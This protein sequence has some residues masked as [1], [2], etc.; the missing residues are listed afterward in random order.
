MSVTRRAFFRWT[1]AGLAASTLGPAAALDAE[2]AGLKT[3]GATKTT[4]I[5]PYCSVGCGTVIHSAGGQVVQVDGDPEHPINRG[6]LCPKGASVA[7]LRQNPKRLTTPLYRAPGATEWK[8][9][10]WDWTVGEIAKR[11]K[12]ARDDSF[13]TVNAKGEVVNRTTALA[14]VGSAALDNEEAY[15]YQKFL[16][17]LGLVYVEHQA[18]L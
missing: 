11:V 13:E 14:S 3:E 12:K 5:C 10:S 6:T 17:G 9:V 7:Q 8:E 4:S 15:L 2:A 1:G 16:R 18:R